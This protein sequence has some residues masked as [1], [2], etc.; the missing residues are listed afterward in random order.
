MDILVQQG[1]VT[2]IQTPLLVVNLFEGVTSPGGA[3]GAVDS[4][5]GGLLSQLI[6][7]GEIRGKLEEVSVIHTLG[8]LPAQRVAVV[9]LGPRE[10]FSLEAVR[11]ASGSAL[12]KAQELRVKE[13]HTIVHGGG[14]GA[15]GVDAGAQATVEGTLLANYSYRQYKAPEDE[16]EVVRM[17]FVER[18]AGKT[19]E[20]ERAITK[21][22]AYAEATIAARE[23]AAGPPNLV[24]PEYLAERAR[25]LAARYGLDCQ[26]LGPEEME[27]HGMGAIL[28]VG[29]GS[30]HPPRLVAIRYQGD[31]SSQRWL[32]LVGKGITFDSGGISI[33]PA[34][35][36]EQM[37][38]D[39]AGACA[40]LGAMQGIAELKLKANVLGVIGAAE[41][42]PSSHS[43]RPGD[44]VRASN[45]KTIEVVNTDAEGRL[46]LADALSYAVKQGADPVV[47]I[48]TLTGGVVVA[49]GTGGA[50]VMGNDETLV[51]RLIEAGDRVGERLWELPIWEDYL[52]EQVKSDVA[53]IMNSGGRYGS[54]PVGGLF[55][56]KF[57][58]EAR[59]AHLD[60]AGT[61]WVDTDQPY[62]PKAYIPRG[63]TGFGTRLFLEFVQAWA[64]QG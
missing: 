56:S 42:L 53:D 23:L 36:M 40:V 8:K 15:L 6:A 1:S 10:Q 47:D 5:L 2:E 64:T 32:G 9:G 4:A 17:V 31:L 38:Y 26:V 51:R 14:I 27:A 43:Y 11:R 21:G 49:L 24:D 28:A 55:L 33:K 37:K 19:A 12:K 45:G 62:L 22:N 41:N 39:K 44:I 25:E 16:T 18:D 13:Y 48:A 34:Q 61:A 59:W 3:T 29:Q 20:I 50:G 60:I 58:G 54:A 7:E 35:H 57:V 30:D 46:V 63:P 52:W